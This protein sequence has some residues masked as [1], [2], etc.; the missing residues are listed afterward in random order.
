VQAGQQNDH[1]VEAAAIMNIPL[2]TIVASDGECGIFSMV[3]S[4][5][6]VVNNKQS[7]VY[8]SSVFDKSFP[9]RMLL[10]PT[11]ALLT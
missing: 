1:L 3:S 8:G 10:V 2:I 4:D 6:K 7:T 9:S 5:G 11:L